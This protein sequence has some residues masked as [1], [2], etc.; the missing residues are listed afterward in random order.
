[1][2]H[3][4]SPGWSYSVSRRA[5]ACLTSC[6]VIVAAGG[7]AP[8]RRVARPVQSSPFHR[9]S[10]AGSGRG[11]VLLV[12]LLFR[13]NTAAEGPACRRCGAS[14]LFLICP[15]PLPLVDK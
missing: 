3:G 10:A 6:V 7:P 1:M 12:L 14:S 9:T 13:T 15:L 2:L 8:S 11:G 5:P 4:G